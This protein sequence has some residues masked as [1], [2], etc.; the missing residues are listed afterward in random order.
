MSPIRRITG[1]AGGRNCLRG[2]TTEPRSYSSS[3]RSRERCRHAPGAAC[4]SAPSGGYDAGYVPSLAA[5]EDRHFWFRARNVV[6]RAAVTKLEARLPSGYRVLEIGC[7]T[8]N[9]LR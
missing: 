1:T 2:E 4:M 7:G 8:G 6:I 3:G 9:T 5:V